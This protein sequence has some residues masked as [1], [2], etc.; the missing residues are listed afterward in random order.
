MSVEH[1]LCKL[2]LSPVGTEVLGV[3]LA[4][5]HTASHTELFPSKGRVL[6]WWSYW[7][8][9]G[10]NH[11]SLCPSVDRYRLTGDTYLCWQTAWSALSNSISLSSHNGVVTQPKSRVNAW[12]THRIWLCV[13]VRREFDHFRWFT[14]W[15][16]T[17]ELRKNYGKSTQN[18]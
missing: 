13:F 12:T 14:R 8:Q 6:I 15:K 10:C 4:V 3:A 18:H 9:F 1:T 7:V 17:D 2:V 11:C 5:L 16:I